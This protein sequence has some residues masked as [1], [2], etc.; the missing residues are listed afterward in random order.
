MSAAMSAS[1]SSAS[2]GNRPATGWWVMPIS[3]ILSGVEGVLLLG[4]LGSGGPAAGPGGGV[5][6][7][8]QPFDGRAGGGL[9][10][11]GHAGVVQ[12][13]QGLAG[14]VVFQRDAAAGHDPVHQ[15]PDR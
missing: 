14:G 6:G 5:L 4:S 12:G 2:I 8:A 11:L 15:G 10:L 9:D 13:G 1:S 3:V 7:A